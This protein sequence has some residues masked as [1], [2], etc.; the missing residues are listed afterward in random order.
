MIRTYDNKHPFWHNEYDAKFK[1]LLF[2]IWPFAAWVYSLRTANTRSS[3]I[4]FFLFSLLLCW[5]MTAVPGSDYD[6]FKGILERFETTNDTFSELQFKIAS[7]FSGADGAPKE[8]YEIIMIYIVKLF[9]DNYHFYFLL[10]AIPVAFCQLES[11]KRITSDIRYR[12]GTWIAIFILIMFIFPRDIITVQNPR[13]TT[14]FWICLVCSLYYFS[15]S[16]K[17]IYYLLPIALT[18]MIHSGLW[19]YLILILVFTLIPKNIRLLEFLAICSIPISF[20]DSNLY[21]NLNLSFLPDTLYNWSLLHFNPDNITNQ[22]DLRAGYWWV[23]T[24]FAYAMKI[25][26]IYMLIILIK[27]KQDVYNNEEASKF[28]PFYLYI[29]TIIN[30][31]KPI[32]VLGERYYWFLQIFTVYLWFKAFYPHRSKAIIMLMIASSWGLLSRYGYVVGGALSVTTE[33][34]MFFTPLP[35]LMGKGLFW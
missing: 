29:V 7:Y 18:P 5:H 9:T 28:Y 19:L 2:L 13:F 23:G 31:I 30:F 14:G 35:Y 22:A 25:V 34:D 11:L 10:C 26:Y 6:D 21:H 3:Y 15:E 16:K 17:H 1:F 20:F 27:N 4:I 8:I 32:P 33:L 24:S 12:A